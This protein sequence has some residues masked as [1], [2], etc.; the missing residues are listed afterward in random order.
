MNDNIYVKVMFSSLTRAA[1]IQLYKEV[2]GGT[3]DQLIICNAGAT[4]QEKI[5]IPPFVVWRLI[6][7]FFSL[8][9]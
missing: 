2:I 5:R 3:F 4:G 1:K 6:I 8:G 7:R 9:L